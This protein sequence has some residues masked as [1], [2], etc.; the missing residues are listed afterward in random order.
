MTTTLSAPV[1]AAP[2]AQATLTP[3]NSTI[4]DEI[5]DAIG[6][7]PETYLT[8][9][10]YAVSP[11]STDGD[12]IN[13]GDEV[14]FRVRVNNSGPLDALDLKLLIEAQDGATGVKVHGG[15]SFQSNLVT[16]PITV[17]ARQPDGSWTELPDDYH[18]L[19][20][21][22]SKDKVDLVK[23]FLWDWDGGLDYL[24]I[25]HTNRSDATSKVYS[26]KVLG[27]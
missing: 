26:H 9:N 4:L 23:V 18:F 1:A 16:A 25:H 7:Y 27:T 14:T 10:I 11:V 6:T 19:A 21:P 17:P 20:G 22:E 24:L 8:L 5:A 3:T 2:A 15:S 12:E 13:A